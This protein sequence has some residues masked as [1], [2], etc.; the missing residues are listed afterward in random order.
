MPENPLNINREIKS[1][2]DYLNLIRTKNL[3]FHGRRVINASRS[4]NDNDYVTKAELDE[5]GTGESGTS[6]TNVT[7]LTE[8]KGI[9]QVDFFI[10]H[11]LAILINAGQ[12]IYLESD[13]SIT[14]Y[15][16]A[17]KIASTGK[18]ILFTVK[19]DGVEIITGSLTENLLS[20][21][22][23][24]VEG[25]LPKNV[26]ITVDLTQIGTTFPGS[27]FLLSLR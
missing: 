12:Q 21:G 7:E 19:G 17:V 3:D 4:V 2:W 16:A 24:T 9:A 23:V 8:V 13:F 6:I 14:S 26:A 15:L 18:D 5:I 11:T 10:D 1:I 27:D 25:I 22:V 20:S